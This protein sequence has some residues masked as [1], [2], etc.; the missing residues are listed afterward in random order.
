MM[1]SSNS[2]KWSNSESPE[3]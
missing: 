2:R 3:H 1:K